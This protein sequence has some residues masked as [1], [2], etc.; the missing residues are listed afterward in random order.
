MNDNSDDVIPESGQ[1]STE[2]S[3]IKKVTSK[4]VY[5]LDVKQNVLEYLEKNDNQSEAGRVFNIHP[6]LISYWVKQKDDIKNVSYKR[7][8]TR[9]TKKIQAKFPE[10]EQRLSE[11]FDQEREKNKCV[12][13]PA[14]KSKAL[15]LHSQIYSN[16]IS[17]NGFQASDG[18]LGGW[19]DRLN[20]TFRRVTTTGRDLPTNYSHTIANFLNQT[21]NVLRN[22]NFN[23]SKIFNMDETSIYLDCPSRYTYENKGAKRVKIDTNGAELVRISAIYTASADGEKFPIFLLVPRT[24]ELDNYEPPNNIKLIYK[25]GGTFND[26]TIC[27]Y[28]VTILGNHPKSTLYFDSARFHVT[29][30]VKDKLSQLDLES[31][32]IPPRMTNLLQPAD[33]CWF[34]KIKKAY[35]TKWSKWSRN[36]ERTYTV[37]GNTRSPGYALAISWLSEIWHDFPAKYPIFNSITQASAVNLSNSNEN[38]HFFTNQ[39]NALSNFTSLNFTPAS[40]QVSDSSRNKNSRRLVLRDLGNTVYASQVPPSA[41]SIGQWRSL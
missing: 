12:S 5:Y 30:K 18:W 33:V 6:R 7:K 19:L 14:L 22:N 11:W 17:Q 3:C 31:F 24:K 10:M 36:S 39:I 16:N 28:L 1:N 26:E 34:S 27:D 9:V 35:C 4:K 23:R 40:T 20:K 38:S 29:E 21:Q 2:P 41:P 13:G 37:H 8:K 32:Y 25:T 15:Q